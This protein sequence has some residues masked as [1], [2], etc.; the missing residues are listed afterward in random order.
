M[1]PAPLL[2]VPSVATDNVKLD[3]D[4][5]VEPGHG[6]E[7]YT[8]TTLLMVHPAL[9]SVAML[10]VA[11]PAGAQNAAD[12]KNSVNFNSGTKTIDITDQS[13]SGSVRANIK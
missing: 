10:I 5:N 2:T 9:L 7:P 1:P 3:A 12:A 13:S 8:S 6:D 4:G 11:A